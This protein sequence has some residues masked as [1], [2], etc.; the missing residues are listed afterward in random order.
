MANPLDV[1]SPTV[2]AYESYVFTKEIASG[3]AL[4]TQSI[5]SIFNDAFAIHEFE[6][7]DDY[8]YARVKIDLTNLDSEHAQSLGDRVT[9]LLNSPEPESYRYL[10]ASTAGCLYLLFRY[11]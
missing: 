8:K 2:V 10:F 9:V 3:I 1:I 7:P 5:A 11:F 4:P 6:I